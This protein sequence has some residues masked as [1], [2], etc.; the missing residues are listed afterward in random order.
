MHSELTDGACEDALNAAASCSATDEVYRSTI[1]VAVAASHRLSMTCL[2]GHECHL[3]TI[4]AFS[5]QL[6]QSVGECAGSGMCPRPQNALKL[7]RRRWNAG[8]L[9]HHPCRRFDNLHLRH[10]L[11]RCFFTRS[12]LLHFIPRSCTVSSGRSI[13]FFFVIFLYTTITAVV[14]PFRHHAR[15]LQH[16]NTRC[17]Q[18]RFQA[19]RRCTYFSLLFRQ[20]YVTSR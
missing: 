11:R 8:C 9:D 1:P 7:S 2:N 3:A 15:C 6:G 19:L 13:F 16:N 12:S 20:L 17:S 18:Q 14:F 4:T 10:A 5:C